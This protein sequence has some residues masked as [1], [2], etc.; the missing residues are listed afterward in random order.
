MRDR[1]TQLLIYILQRIK[2][3]DVQNRTA[4]PFQKVSIDRGT[5]ISTTG[6]QGETRLVLAK[7][8][9][10]QTFEAVH[11]LLKKVW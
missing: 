6:S 11:H 5:I 3:R 8:V 4:M 10:I 1:L 2:L 9:K 7:F